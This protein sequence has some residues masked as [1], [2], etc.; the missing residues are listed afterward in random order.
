MEEEWERVSYKL[1][2]QLY[3]DFCWKNLISFLITSLHQI[4]HLL[5]KVRVLWGKP[6]SCILVLPG[7]DFFPAGLSES[8]VKSCRWRFFKLETVFWFPAIRKCHI[9]CVAGRKASKRKRLKPET[10]PVDDW[11]DIIYYIFNMECLESWIGHRTPIWPTFVEGNCFL[12][13]SD[14]MV[15]KAH[16]NTLVLFIRFL[17]ASV[18]F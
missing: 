14:L 5:E 9:S 13:L 17:F 1:Q 8:F 18:L 10:P 4:F 11:I 2:A 3:G 6:L 12:L 15:L 7:V 16:P